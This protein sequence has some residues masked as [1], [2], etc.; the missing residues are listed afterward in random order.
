MKKLNLFLRV[1]L[2]LF[3]GVGGLQAH[4]GGTVY[5]IYELPTSSLP[6][7]HDGTLEDWEEVLPGPIID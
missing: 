2:L 4:V 5:S 1:T 6:D 3:A 7:L